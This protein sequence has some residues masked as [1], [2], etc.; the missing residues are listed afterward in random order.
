MPATPGT[1][2]VTLHID[3]LVDD[4]ELA[5]STDDR[6]A[7]EGIV[8]Q[9]AA[10]ATSV[11][12]PSNI[13]LYGPWGS[14]KSGIANLLKA[15]IDGKKGVRCVRFDAFKYA[16]VPLRRNFISAIATELNCTNRKYHADLYSGRTK[17]E[18]TVPASTIAKLLGVFALLLLGLTAIIGVV[19]AIAALV[20]SQVGHNTAFGT[21]FR[22]LANQVLLAGLLPA[23]LLAAL[24]S[25][26][27]KTFSVDRSIAKPESDEQF[28]ELFRELVD[29]TRAKRLVVFV[30]ELDR[31]S[32][33][34]VVATLDT[35]RTFLGIDRCVFIIAAD[36]NVLEEALTRAAKQETPANDSNPYYSTG[37]AYLDKVFQYQISL[38]PLLTQSIS[39]YA[40][41]LVTN[42]GGLWAEINIEY[43]LSILIPTHVTSPR[44][45]K[46]LLNAFA[47]TY[48]MAQERH[49]AELL[50][51]D[52]VVNAASIARLACLRVE[53]PLFARHLEVAPDLPSL[54]LQFMRNEEATLPSGTSERAAELARSYAL[55]QAPPSTVLVD[56][57]GNDDEDDGVERTLVAHN[58]QLLNYLSRTRQVVG[59]SRDLLYMQSTGTVFGLDGDLALAIERA[60]EDADIDTLQQRINGLDEQART[61]VLQL[62][63]DQIRTGTGVTG[64]NA[65]RSF[66]LL[67][68]DNP[69]LPVASVVDSVIEAIC[70]AQDDGD[71]VLDEDTLT[72]AWNLAKAGSEASA[73]ALRQRVLNM[74]T[75]TEESPPN[76]IF[77][78]AVQAL[79]AAPTA[80]SEYL[81]SRL[82]ADTCADT[83]ERIFQ[84]NDGDLLS[85]VNTVQI[86]VAELAREAATAHSEWKKAQEEGAATPAVT[87]TAAGGGDEEPF[88][89]KVL[90]D[91]LA[92]AAQPRETPVQHRLLDLV[93]T[94]GVTDARHAAS[95]LIAH[96]EPTEDARLVSRILAATYVR[97]LSEWPAWLAGIKPSAIAAVHTQPIKSLVA[98]AWTNGNI[99][100]KQAALD[101]L[102]P[103]IEMLPAANR[104]DVTA[105]V[106]EEVE[107]AVESNDEATK[108]RDV[109]S[110]ARLFADAKVLDIK[111]VMSAVVES[112]QDTLAASVAV[113]ESN[114]AL[115]EYV[116]KDGAEA[117]HACSGE[118][119]TEQ[120]GS[121]LNEASASRWLNDLGRVEV[122]LEIAK[123]AGPEL[124][125]VAALP[126]A[127]T[128][129]EAV[130]N[131][132][133]AAAH[134][135]SLWIELVRP[136]PE[137][138][139]TVFENLRAEEALSGEMTDAVRA[140]QATWSA[141]QMRGFLDR[142]LA[143]PDMEVPNELALK[144]IGLAHADDTDVADLLC[145]RFAAA[146][147]NAQRQS[148]IT[149]WSQAQVQSNPSRRK[150]VETI[151]YGLLDIHATTPNGNI[152]AAEMALNALGTVGRPL[153]QGIKGALG[154]RV[155]NAVSGTKTL[156]KK[157]LAIMPE[158][159]YSTST[160]FLG[161]AKRVNFDE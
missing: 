108:R 25:L 137:E 133:S 132:G 64:P 115:Y 156:E 67:V 128:V 109:L 93:L 155:K 146:T 131:Y 35:V 14:G 65:A 136:R 37:S 89:P 53:F 12:T 96:T 151:I 129:A 79:D 11:K 2:G 27:S 117:I 86:R 73:T 21:E 111:A 61:G 22:A 19:V 159:G 23:A 134:A 119:S 17:T 147:N 100:E 38:P 102:K 103:F 57:D 18:V 104:P 140:A 58:K 36:Q 88:N 4:R 33:G 160:N 150:L 121:I 71:G 43:V 6:L 80:M 50:A 106:L 113:A 44:R 20:Q 42:R 15:K 47:L 97:A 85:V 63:A 87:S 84:L 75:N 118:L 55:E 24:I 7:H 130:D 3:D 158:L 32:A 69:D 40:N 139:A 91:A 127:S 90:F 46:H 5:A 161:R 39:N 148:V 145:K 135:A 30:D 78:D 9:L 141:D 154:Q 122:P 77:D 142:Y 153:P 41:T 123:S 82:V 56:E 143:A 49:R 29:D 110:C 149:L 45:V 66:L 54:V 59:P 105:D 120:I 48:R 107:V 92:N 62:L 10:L 157:A 152:G 95:R 116:L 114:D 8:D 52:P 98:K 138:L 144:T 31:C 28:E 124:L 26:A 81:A 99:G 51:E 1:A 68:E 112:M 126:T 74:V 83:V 125:S 34:E 60:A 13:A 101:V 72:S 76:F 94:V 70:V 16:D